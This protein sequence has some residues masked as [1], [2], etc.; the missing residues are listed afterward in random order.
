[1]GNKGTAM[2]KATETLN[3]G[4]Y[5]N[6]AGSLDQISM[7]GTNLYLYKVQL[8]IFG[9]F[10]VLFSIWV[11]LKF[12]LNSEFPGYVSA[13]FWDDTSCSF[14]LLTYHVNFSSILA[15]TCPVITILNVDSY[16]TF[17]DYILLYAIKRNVKNVK[18]F[19]QTYTYK[20]EKKKA[21]HG[22]LVNVQEKK[23]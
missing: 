19:N 16:F 22:I 17:E 3:S 18:L 15:Q 10:S 2:P 9:W 11:P 13:H 7:I 5:S 23:V 1:M 12:H 8:G 4:L 20:A 6:S 21:T 14:K